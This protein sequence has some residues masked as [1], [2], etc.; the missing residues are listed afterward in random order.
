M[1]RVRPPT[2]QLLAK[3]FAP[4]LSTVNTIGFLTLKPID[5][6]N[7]IENNMSCAQ[8]VAATNSASVTD[9]VIQSCILLRIEI[10]AWVDERGTLMFDIISY[11]N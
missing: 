6:I 3:S 7:R 10:G 8:A 2:L 4:L 1:C 9:N 11:E 5:S